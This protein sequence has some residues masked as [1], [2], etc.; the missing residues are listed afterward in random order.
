VFVLK[1]TTRGIESAASRFDR[2]ASGAWRRGLMTVVGGLVSDQTRRRIRSEKT[3]PSGTKWAAWA[4]STAARRNKSHSLLVFTGKL[5]ASITHN[6]GATQT[7]I[8]A[9]VFYA[10]FLQDG[11]S[12]MVA[13]RFLGLSSKNEDEVTRAVQ[14]FVLARLG[15]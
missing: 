14:S 15:I 9:P 1:I 5:L 7:E 12:R 6:D 13:R 8:G 2:V 11:T 10:A 4:P 3:D